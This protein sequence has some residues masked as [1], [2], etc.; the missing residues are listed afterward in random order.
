M[1][2]AVKVRES[3]TRGYS[4]FSITIPKRFVEELGLRK[5]DILFVRSSLKR[6]GTGWASLF[7]GWNEPVTFCGFIIRAR[8]KNKKIFPE[9]LTYF[10]RSD[11][12]RRGLVASSGQVAITNI[13]QDVL[14]I[15]RFPLP[16]FDE[17]KRIAK[18]LSI[19][20]RKI[21]IERKEKEKLERIKQGLMDLLLT[22]KI[23]VKVN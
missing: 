9:F 8:L 18:I 13:T 20:D 2:E 21:E 3:K 16:P 11:F 10:L 1:V 19:V 7:N 17:Q 23:R 6:E 12:A 22:G 14:K 4:V 5:G 15:L